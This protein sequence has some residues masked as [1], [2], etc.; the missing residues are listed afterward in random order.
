MTAIEIEDLDDMSEAKPE[1]NEKRGGGDISGKGPA[2]NN[3]SE[4]SSTSDKSSSKPTKDY[5][6][7]LDPPDNQ[8]GAWR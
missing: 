2:T 8:G 5:S 4:S 3:P 6:I 1:P 7:P